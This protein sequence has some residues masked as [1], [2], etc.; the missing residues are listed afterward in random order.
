MRKGSGDS[1]PGN[2]T[3]AL[4]KEQNHNFAERLIDSKWIASGSPNIL[5]GFDTF[6]SV[7]QFHAREGRN[8][9]RC[10]RDIVAFESKMQ[11]W[12]HR[13]ENGRIPAF[14]ALNAFAEEV[15]IDSAGF[16]QSFLSAFLHLTEMDKC[17]PSH[18]YIK[19]M[20][21]TFQVPEL[22]IY[23][24]VDCIAEPLIEMQSRQLWSLIQ[25]EWMSKQWNQ[26]SLI[27][28]RRQQKLFF[29]FQLHTA[30]TLFFNTNYF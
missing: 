25:F 14:S 1:C 12:I 6:E 27:C 22:Q 29:F 2:A 19:N 17:I 4:L 23:C 28:V 26:I 5:G 10:V 20:R 8:S 11:L 7:E 30:V 13:I 3:G 9:F 21:S 18:N 24:E 15:E 16:V